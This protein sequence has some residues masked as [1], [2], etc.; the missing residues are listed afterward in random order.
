MKKDKIN[1][2]FVG[3]GTGGHITPIFSLIQTLQKDTELKKRFPHVYR[4]G[5]DASME[6]EWAQKINMVEF[7][8]ISG[9]KWRRY[10]DIMS[11]LRNFQDIYFT[12][13]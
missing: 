1:I 13:K 12:G 7:I 10:R 9:G 8:A 6:Q 5:Q 2:A 4:F 3:G 11:I